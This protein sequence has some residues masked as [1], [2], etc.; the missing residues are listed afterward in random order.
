MTGD[1]VTAKQKNATLK[2][3]VYSVFVG[4]QPQYE[5]SRQ[6]NVRTFRFRLRHCYQAVVTKIYMRRRNSVYPTL[7]RITPTLRPVRKGRV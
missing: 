5:Q 3:T 7:F 6:N 1:L 4:R 2:Y